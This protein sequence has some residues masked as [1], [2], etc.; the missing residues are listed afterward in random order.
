M[1]ISSSYFFQTGLNSINAQ[2]ADLLHLYQ[3][4]AS[5]QRMVTPADDPLGAAQA[6]NL[7]QS[8]SLNERFA[9]NRE[10][11]K[12]NLGQEENVLR[13][14][15]TLLQDIKTALIEAGNGTRSDLDRQTLA[16]VLS[17]AKDNLLGL[18][19]STDGNGQYIFSGHRSMQPAFIQGSNGAVSYNGDAGGRLIQADPTRQIDS[20]DIGSSVFA[21]A[22]SGSRAYV[23]EANSANTGTAAIGSPTITDPAGTNVGMPFK[24]VFEDVPSPGT[25]LQYNVYTTGAGGAQTRIEGPKAYDPDATTLRLDGGV[26]VGISGRAAAGDV[27]SINPANVGASRAY[28]VDSTSFGAGA[29]VGTAISDPAGAYL[30]ASF[31][32]E[33]TE[34]TPGDFEYSVHVLDANGDPVLDVNNDPVIMGPTAFVPAA[35]PATTVILRLPDATGGLEV[36]VSGSLA[37]GNSFLVSPAASVE[38]EL[39][40]FD[41]LDAI[42]QALSADVGGDP[43]GQA[44]L[45]NALASAMQKIDINYDQILTVRASV[46]ARMNEIDAIDANG[47]SRGLGYS[48]QLSRLEDVDYY[49]VTTQ[50]ELRRAALEAAAM[51]FKKIQGTSLFNMGS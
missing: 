4:T 40:V 49:Q 45:S 21:S 27:F 29:I 15:T 26:Q 22:A 28:S 23:T 30:G 3:Q 33:F 24:I 51:A 18:A 10:V 37:D 36:E 31:R 7:S 13:S 44:K 6:V 32:V 41:T 48:K 39:N 9:A 35:P 12:L 1:R 5:G 16:T 50:L 2:Q 11:L 20:S 42:I 19:N 43:L 17:K 46:G 8:Q 25:G 34:P 14:A 38:P 47:E